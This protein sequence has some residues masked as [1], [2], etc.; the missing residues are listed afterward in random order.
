MKLA[1][2]KAFP[3]VMP[4]PNIQTPRLEEDVSIYI[5]KWSAKSQGKLLRD[6]LETTVRYDS[7]CK[8]KKK[9]HDSIKHTC[10]IHLGP[11]LQYIKLIGKS[12]NELFT[13]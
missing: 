4:P 7:I 13:F 8:K 9:A 5:M 6:C 2:T 1:R 10:I 11:R 12:S 3:L